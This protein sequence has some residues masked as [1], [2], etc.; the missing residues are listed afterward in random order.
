MHR[1]QDRIAWKLIVLLS[2]CKNSS[3]FSVASICRN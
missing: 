2:K 3:Q 1:F